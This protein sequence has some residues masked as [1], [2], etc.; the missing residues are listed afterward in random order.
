M[1]LKSK[2]LV[3]ENIEFIA[4][5][6]PNC[7]TE[8]RDQRGKISH[9]IDFDLLKQELSDHLI[10]EGD[11][12]YML[13]WAGKKQSILTANSPI[14][15]TLRPC[16][17]ESVDFEKTKNLYIEGDNL[18]VLKVLRETYFKKVKLIYIDPPYNTGNDFVYNDDFAS[19]SEEYLKNSKSVDEQGNKLFQ[20]NDSNG[21]FHSDWLSMMY[22]RLKIAKDYLMDEGLIFISI[23]ENE[24]T[25]LRKLCDEIFGS[26]NFVGQ[27][28][29]MKTATPPSLSKNIRKKLEYI[30]CYSK[31]DACNGLNGGYVEGGD[32]PLL[33]EVNALGTLR[34]DKESVFFKINDGHYK[35]GEKDRVVLEKDIDVINGKAQQDIVLTA[36][37]KWS[38]DT[39]DSEIQKG[40]KFWIKS[41][42]FAIRYAREGER[43]KVPSN[44]ISKDECE[45]GTNEDAQ[46]DIIKLFGGKVMDYPKPVSLI[47]YLVRMNTTDDD[48]VMDFFSGSATTAHAVMQLNAEDNCNRRFIMV[49]LPEICD[50]DSDAYRAGYKTICEVGKERIRRAGNTVKKDYNKNDLDVG[51]RDFKLDSSCMKDVYYNPTELSQ[52]FLTQ[53]ESNIK[54][55][56]TPEDLLF[57]VM[58]TMGI[59]LSAKIE[60]VEI[61]GKKV[62]KV[63]DNDLICCFDEKLTKDVIT[64]IAKM[65]PV[66][67]RFK[68]SSLVSDSENINLEQIFEMYSSTT[69]RK[70]I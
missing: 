27:F 14:T 4:Q 3:N 65:H 34:F 52:S 2:D 57:Q 69:D 47:K 21:R 10:D 66:Y 50:E 63:D 25:N 23:D 49:Q 59:D 31:S 29:W 41:D 55:D 42:K 51:F 36:H 64:E 1:E 12:R 62:F 18:D 61:C 32:M 35:A 20:N 22:S 40:T 30:L 70:V 8:V 28:N 16:K 37:F 44:I 53:L 19:S 38:Q 67:A 54:E 5:K 9:C 58:L 48:I 56:R 39:L 11:E 45:V 7:V 17:K 15:K 60:E 68:D 13:N 26:S 43:I 6:F 46:K 33:N 24:V